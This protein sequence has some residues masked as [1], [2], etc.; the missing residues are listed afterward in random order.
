MKFFLYA[1]FIIFFALFIFFANKVKYNEY[2]KACINGKIDTIYRYRSCVMITVKD[3]EFSIVPIADSINNYIQLDAI[4]KI[5]DSVFKATN[6][7]TLHL[8]HQGN[9]F[10][11]TVERY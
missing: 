2:H 10:L 3:K 6:N 7:D 9:R 5:R 8:I 11:Y 4:A 1:I